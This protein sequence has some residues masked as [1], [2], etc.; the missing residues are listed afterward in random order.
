MPR[1]KLSELF[2]SVQGEGGWVGIPSTFVRL[3]GCN[4][5]CVWCDTPY[6]SW[7]PEGEFIELED[8]V[9][10]INATGLSHVVLTGGEPM[11][12][13]A[14]VALTQELR[15]LGKV[16]TIE[17]AGTIFRDLACDLMSISPK[18][19]HSAPPIETSENWHA[20]HEAARLNIEVLTQL[21]E[22]YNCQLKFVV[23]GTDL[24]PQVQEIKN[25]LNLLPKVAP[26]S[27]LLMAEGVVADGLHATQTRLV[28][29][30]M[31]QG[32]R[33]SPRLHIDLFGNQRGT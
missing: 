30:C 33:L 21:L 14:I 25:L 10:K 11:L 17:T 20:R 7:N 28:P 18:L 23:S 13:D 8:L 5:R 15:R 6:A 24:S 9:E 12:S 2:A 16:I 3:S 31:E 26:E 1:F 27:V 29:I 32:W 19:A 4:L 22:A